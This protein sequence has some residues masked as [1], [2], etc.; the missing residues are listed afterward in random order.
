M[1]C[2]IVTHIRRPATDSCRGKRDAH[3]EHVGCANVCQEVQLL[4]ES[5]VE[6]GTRLPNGLCV[7]PHCH[8]LWQ[9]AQLASVRHRHNGQLQGATVCA[10]RSRKLTRL[11]S[12]RYNMTALSWCERSS[13]HRPLSLLSSNRAQEQ[14]SHG[15]HDWKGQ[16]HM[17]GAQCSAGH[18]LAPCNTTIISHGQSSRMSR[19][20]AH[21]TVWLEQLHQI[22]AQK[23][24][25]NMPC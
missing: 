14:W 20:L 22:L 15:L 5:T 11:S 7:A 1:P 12:C 10:R 17:S 2:L 3:L 9:A 18:G 6:R 21:S 24:Q 16:C 13:R 19:G 25:Q 23:K 8:I 4:V